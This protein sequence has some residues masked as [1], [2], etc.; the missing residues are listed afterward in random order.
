VVTI[1]DMRAF[2]MPE[3]FPPGQ[4]TWQRTLLRRLARTAR[5]FITVSEFSRERILEWLE[6]AD[7]RVEVIPNGVDHGRMRAS[8]PKRVTATLE[9]LGINSPYFLALPGAGQHKDIPM[10]A[11]AWVAARLARRGYGLVIAGTC[12]RPAEDGDGVVWPGEIADEHLAA[13]YSGAV[14]FLHPSRYE[15]FGLTVLEAMACGTPVAAS[16]AGALPEVVGE[17]GLLLPPGGV[18]E[19]ADALVELESNAR[20]RQELGERG[21]R[22]AALYDWGET[23]GLTMDILRHAA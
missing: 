3:T 21:R 18:Q 11:S 13:L 10:L 15:G 1:H 20:L 7:S 8:D 14:A 16:R 2:D 4:G 5:G 9:A 12:N 23:A 17:A 19:W 6:I 22:R